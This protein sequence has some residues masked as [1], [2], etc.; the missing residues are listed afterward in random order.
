MQLQN[1]GQYTY[2]R[3]GSCYYDFTVQSWEM[4]IIIVSPLPKQA[5]TQGHNFALQFLLKAERFHFLICII[6]MEIF[7]GLMKLR[8]L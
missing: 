5:P 6:E 1:K 4:K 2:K 3:K 8:N 7:Y